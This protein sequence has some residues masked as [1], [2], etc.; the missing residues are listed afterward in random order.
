MV[1]FDLPLSYVIL[2]HNHALDLYLYS[3]HIFLGQGYKGCIGL[4]LS[5]KQL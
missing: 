1:G 5:D 4:S 2:N 3:H